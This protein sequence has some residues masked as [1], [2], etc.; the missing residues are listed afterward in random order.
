M[1]MIGRDREIDA[2]IAALRNGSVLL[3][4]GSAGMGKSTLA[5]EV[6]SSVAGAGSIVTLDPSQR[7]PRVSKKAA[8][9]IVDGRDATP[10][11]TKAAVENAV[12]AGS[13]V[14]VVSPA[15]LGLQGETIVTL[16]P[17]ERNDAATLFRTLAADVVVKNEA[18]E[19]LVDKLEGIPLVIELAARRASVLGLAELARRLDDPVKALGKPL[20]RALSSSFELLS[21]AERNA[22]VSASV[23]EGTFTAESFEEVVGDID[24]VEALLARSLLFRVLGPGSV[25]LGMLRVVRAFARTKLDDREVLRRH[26]RHVLSRAESLASK[27]YGEGAETALDELEAIAPDVLAAMNATTEPQLVA[28][29]FLSLFDAILF[30]EAIDLR[31]PRF[32]V[33]V[34]AA[35]RTTN[36]A[37]Q[38]RSRVLRARARLE[39]GPPEGARADAEEAV[40]KATDANLAAEAKRTLGWAHIASGAPE[41]AL[42]ALDEA[43][44][45][46]ALAGDVR[47]QADAFAASGLAHT[48][49]GRR[50][51]GAQ[52]LA[53]ARAIHV[54]QKDALRQRKVEDMIRLVGAE[55]DAPSYREALTASAE[56]HAKRGQRWREAID[57]ALLAHVESASGKETEA[58]ALR[59]RARAA[60]IAAGVAIPEPP[61][62]VT[63][64]G[65]SV[66]TEARFAIAPDGTHHDLA[67]HGP[68]RRVLEALVEARMTSPGSAISADDVLLA[69]W[70]EEKMRHDAGMLRVYSIIRRLR[71]LGLAKELLTRDDGY[72]LDPAVSFAR[73][74]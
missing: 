54:G 9:T 34:E 52:K 28:R 47:G 64:K 72:L 60:A 50:E 53:L 26:A 43:L 30:R 7:S 63:P 31:D 6:A 62:P 13:R 57:L 61:S 41:E 8:V 20:E 67:R 11:R 4:C 56:H 33:A 38:T 25:R 14:I 66:A 1:A 24:L 27:T 46:H 19:A 16:G 45:A 12:R 65:W 32:D 36:A 5:R 35:D 15:P 10:S 59:V 48:F 40:A 49:L 17:L 23:F 22:L 18:L 68:L 29:S 39:V 69:G 74:S 37:L 70:P 44:E 2:S 58:E 55:F 42:V 73:I 21:E 51:T 71:G 3:V